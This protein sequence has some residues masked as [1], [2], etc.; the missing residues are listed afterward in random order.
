MPGETLRVVLGAAAGTEIQLD[1]TFTLGRTESG[2]GSLGGDPEL[3]RQHARISRTGDGALE[4]TDLGSTN[5]T[6]VN[7]VRIVNP[8][9][10]S[11]GDTIRVGQTT[12]NVHGEPTG[13]AAEPTVIG[14][15]PPGVADPPPEA[16]PPAPSSEAPAPPPPFAAPA[17]APASPGFGESAPPPPPASSEQAPAPPPPLEEEAPPPEEAAAPVEEEAP[18]PEEAAAPMEEAASPVPPPPFDAAAAPP[19]PS[20]LEEE[21]PPPEAAPAAPPP[22]GDEAPLPPA[23]TPEDEARPPEAD[24]EPG[25]PPP[26]GPGPQIDERGPFAAPADGPGPASPHGDPLL[27]PHGLA[28]GDPLAGSPPPQPSKQHGDPFAAQS[29]SP[30]TGDETARFDQPPYRPPPPPAVEAAPFDQPPDRLPPPPPGDEITTFDRPPPPPPP[31]GEAARFDPPPGTQ[32]YPPA[33]PVEPGAQAGRPAVAGAYGQGG[34]PVAA[35]PVGP[36]VPTA[37]SDAPSYALKRPIGRQ[38]LLFILS[39]GLWGFYWFYDTRKK[40]NAELGKPDDAAVKTACMLI[41]IYNLV[42]IYQLW[43]DLNQLRTRSFGLPEY[44]S[45]VLLIVAVLVP[46][47][48]FYSYP[49]VATELNQYWDVRTQG[50]ATEAPVTSIEK[51]LAGIGAAILALYVLVIVIVIIAAAAGS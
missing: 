19:P 35:P 8:Y 27:A 18:P 6:H 23:L 17:P 15:V 30:P 5:G 22:F 42:L 7:G 11:A 48:V 33:P 10:L 36:P 31:G 50:R 39:F 44:N 20:R 29:A 28:S 45:A 34:P 3:S 24:S 51:I 12:L 21:A 32:A 26:P 49:K 47:G 13:P 25:R 14:A 16:P 40:L 9:R 38:I 37:G 2:D 4:I 41:P 46:F 43:E 1:D